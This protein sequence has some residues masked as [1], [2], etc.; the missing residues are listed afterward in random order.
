MSD[1]DWDKL[2]AQVDKQIESMPVGAPMAEKKAP[3][4]AAKGASAS[5]APAMRGERVWP[6]Y[7]RLALST[8]LGIGV[9]FW[10]YENRCGLGL[11]GYLIAV[12]FVAIGG[13]WSSVW[14]WRHQTAK[15]HVLSILLIVWG[16][17]LGSAE[18]LPRTGYA[19]QTLQWAC[20]K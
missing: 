11:S 19:K 2:M 5:A 13:I 7:L 9:F 14:T 20:K 17:V 18:V 1:K 10:P 8:A 15:A 4:P 3:A 12:A 16:L 6:A